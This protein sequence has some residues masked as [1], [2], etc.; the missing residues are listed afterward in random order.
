MRF[1][2][3]RCSTYYM[4]PQNAFCV[5]WNAPLG[6]EYF[7]NSFFQFRTHS[8]GMLEVNISI[9][10]VNLNRNQTFSLEQSHQLFQTNRQNSFIT[11][12]SID[13]NESC[14]METCCQENINTFVYFSNGKEDHKRH[15]QKSNV[16][17]IG[18]KL[19]KNYEDL[20]RRL[21]NPDFLETEPKKPNGINVKAYNIYF[22]F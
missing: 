3:A 16:A 2:E 6:D 8:L 21:R 13:T 5:F 14:H 22:L 9:V 4:Y 11:R 20:H 1:R 19:H 12:L 10:E 18:Q 7:S 17:K 15:Y